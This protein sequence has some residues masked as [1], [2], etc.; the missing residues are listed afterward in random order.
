MIL[1]DVAVYVFIVSVL[2]VGVPFYIVRRKAMQEEK[3]S[4]KKAVSI[5]P[6]PPFAQ[7]AAEKRA[8]HEA[9]L[10]PQQKEV[11]VLLDTE[12]LYGQND[13]SR[14]HDDHLLDLSMVVP[15]QPVEPEHIKTKE[16]ELN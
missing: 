4:I 8:R 16:I 7:S 10:K 15:H 14:V 12:N 2:L 3:S 13:T 1:I 6:E 11:E 5:D 9:I